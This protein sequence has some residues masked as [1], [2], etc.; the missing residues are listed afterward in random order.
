MLVNVFRVKR[1]RR[2]RALRVFQREARIF[3]PTSIDKIIGPIRQ[4]GPGQ[5]RNG[6]N[7]NPQPVFRLLEFVDHL[8]QL[9]VEEFA[10][11]Q[12]SGLSGETPIYQRADRDEAEYQQGYGTDPCD[13]EGRDVYSMRQ[14]W[15]H[16]REGSDPA[17]AMPV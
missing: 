5:R 3:E 8:L 12:R 16:H 17:A 15:R 9:P 11:L 14:I 10:F 1:R 2:P 4:T 6:F 7:Q 13:A